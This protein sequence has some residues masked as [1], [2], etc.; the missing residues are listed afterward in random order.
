MYRLVV[1]LEETNIH[2]F[3]FCCYMKHYIVFT[4]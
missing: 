2:V 4:L 1:E 3:H